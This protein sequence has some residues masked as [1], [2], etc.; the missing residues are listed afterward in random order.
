LSVLR[1]VRYTA[2]V[3]VMYT[4]NDQLTINVIAC[5]HSCMQYTVAAIRVWLQQLASS[6]VQYLQPCLLLATPQCLEH[7]VTHDCRR[8]SASD[9]RPPTAAA[10]AAA[11]LACSQQHRLMLPTVRQVE[12]ARNLMSLA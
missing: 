12:A 7:T 6:I 3:S 9:Q 11:L 2:S 10:A 5:P 8:N 1:N 4:V